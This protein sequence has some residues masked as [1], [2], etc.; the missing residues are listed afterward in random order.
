MSFEKGASGYKHLI[1]YCATIQSQAMAL[2]TNTSDS[3]S[4]TKQKYI[5]QTYAFPLLDPLIT[6]II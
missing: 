3:V 1:K 4:E 6:Q 2:A 5:S